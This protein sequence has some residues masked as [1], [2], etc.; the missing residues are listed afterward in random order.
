MGRIRHDHSLER[1]GLSSQQIKSKDPRRRSCGYGLL[2]ELSKSKKKGA[3]DES[4]FLEHI[5]HIHK[6]YDG[7]TLAMQG[8]MGGALMGIGKRT[9][10]LHAA[11]L[12]VARHIG[13][14]K[15]ETDSGNGE[16][17]DVVK[18]L[19]SDYIRKKLGV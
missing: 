15:L 14:I 10:K 19:T 8:S 11:A 9:A 1:G 2:Y 18:H 17:F 13:P 7:E 16:P 3:P 4:F 12:K 5:K 6:S